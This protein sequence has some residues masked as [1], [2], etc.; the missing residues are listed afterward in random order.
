MDMLPGQTPT[1]N[2]HGWLNAIV[3]QVLAESTGLGTAHRVGVMCKPAAP[4]L[5][6]RHIQV[7]QGLGLSRPDG[8]KVRQEVGDKA[9]SPKA[10]FRH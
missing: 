5:G 7:A 4:R 2:S 6:N 9:D 3:G 8:C 10:D 1:M